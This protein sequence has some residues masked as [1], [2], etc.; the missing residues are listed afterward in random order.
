M[1]SK[2]FIAQAAKIT[3]RGGKKKTRFADADQALGNVKVVKTTF[4][5]PPEEHAALDVLRGLAA[6]ENRYPFYSELIRAGL[7]LLQEL[8]T[9]ELGAALDQVKHLPHGRKAI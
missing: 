1:K 4:S 3:N 8:S 7:L 2:D 5:L 6:S 9:Q